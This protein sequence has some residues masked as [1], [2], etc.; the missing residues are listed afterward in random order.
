MAVNGMAADDRRS[1]AST[2][3]RFWSSETLH[4]RSASFETPAEPVLGPAGGRTRGRAPQDEVF[5][6]SVMNVR[7]PEEARSA[8]SK[9]AGAGTQGWDDGAAGVA[10]PSRAEAWY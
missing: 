10:V 4:G 3:M 8:V 6:L 7:H 2:P 9:D 1:A 5:S